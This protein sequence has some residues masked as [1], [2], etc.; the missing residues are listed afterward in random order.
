MAVG[1][2]FPSL[3][4]KARKTICPING[5]RWMDHHHSERP[6]SWKRLVSAARPGRRL[7]A[8]ATRLRTT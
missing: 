2:L 5:T 4:M 8:G 7:A 1:P 6:V 3:A